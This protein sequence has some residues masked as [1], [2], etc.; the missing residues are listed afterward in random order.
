MFLAPTKEQARARV[1]TLVENF[2]RQL[3]DYHRGSYNETQTRR[4]FIDPFFQALGWDID[5]S[6][7]AAEAYREVIHEDKV[8]VGKATKAPDYSF[9]LPGGQ[10]LFFVEAKK[11]SVRIK[12]ELEPAYQVR[13]YG[14]SAKLA[15]SVLTDFEELAVY[16]CTMQPAPTD[17]AAKGRL[18]Y[19]TFREY[20]AEFD[21]LWD[22][23]S[24]ESV[25][26]GGLDKYVA[27]GSGKRGKETVDAAF[28]TT[29]EAMRAE[30]AQGLAT[31]NRHLDADELRF[32][33][34]MLLDRIIFLRIAEDRGIEPYADLQAVA[35]VKKKDK[36]YAGLL[37][38]FKAASARY[39]SGLFD[40]KKDPL[41]AQVHLD[42]AV[43]APLLQSLYYPESPYEFSVIGA[44]IL[45]SAYERF[46]GKVISLEPGRVVRIE[47]KPEVR[48]AGGVF[49]TPAY[50]VNHIVAATLGPRCADRTPQDVAKLRVLDPACGS[51]SFLLGAYQ[52]LLDWHLAY[53]QAHPTAALPPVP[54]SIGKAGAKA[55]PRR[56]GGLTPDG[57]LSSPVKRAI[58]LNNLYGVD[59]DGQAVEVTKL[60][61]LLKCLEGETSASIQ[62]TLGLERV[63][64]TIDQNIR[65]GNSLV[66]TNFYDGEIDF[67][68]DAEK[69]VKP[70][71]WRDEFVAV[72][73]QGGFDVVMGNPPYV[74]VSNMPTEVAQYLQQHYS[75]TNDLYT[76]FLE[77]GMQLTHTGG[78]LSFIVP[79]LFLK[80][81]NSKNVRAYIN[82]HCANFVFEQQGDNVFDQ[83][84]MPTC[85]IITH[86]G[87]AK[88][89][90]DYFA[91]D[92]DGLFIKVKTQPLGELATVTRGL[93]IGRDKLMEAGEYACLT[94]GNIDRYFTKSRKYISAPTRQEFNKNAE[95]F[96]APKLM[97]RETG[98]QFCVTL[99]DEGLLTTRSIY[100][101]KSKKDQVSEKFL[102]GLLGSKLFVFYFKEFISP[103][104]KTFPKVR[105]AQLKELPIPKLSLKISADKRTHDEVVGL[106]DQ[107]LAG[108]A[109]LAAHKLASAKEQAQAKLR[110]LERRLDGLVYDLYQLTEEERAHVSGVSS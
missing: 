1:A 38:R 48:K 28:L 69:T 5:N 91:G 83:V 56:G 37:D 65:V 102:L 40:L 27:T 92:A 26:R 43:L 76:L 30:L 4:D 82:T 3:P 63:L 79:S 66:E 35:R 77:K 50:I 90:R 64:P 88:I 8:K 72:F 18:K 70:F 62:H 108:Y 94:G 104:T 105:I 15:L 21:F 100:N 41:S 44:E 78:Q 49:Y 86:K 53:Y 9:R 61:L 47:D 98:S 10:R 36:V 84:K 54:V 68:P 106:V 42:N 73:K 17:K 55:P 32:L 2:E 12:E 6:S 103:E 57:R 71:G 74:Q 60:S 96:A 39:N 109:G 110:H 99:D 85:I 97:V 80:N 107:L 101:V 25:L 67:A 19:L 58:L 7:G 89:A 51:G 14:W 93:E 52:Y 24:K 81:V 95:V 23:F 31:R 11:P 87:Q 34:Q 16:D 75:L 29:L 13:R 59:L 33:V 46:L 20:A 22:T 45:G